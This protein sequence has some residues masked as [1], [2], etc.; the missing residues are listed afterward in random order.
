MKARNLEILQ[1]IANGFQLKNIAFKLNLSKS[2]IE[3]ELIL[4]REHLNA[5]TTAHAVKIAINKGLI[6]SLLVA[7]VSSFFDSHKYFNIKS[8]ENINNVVFS[9][10]RVVRTS[11]ARRSRRKRNIT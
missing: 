7:S 2:L 10:D 6:V 9:T 1:L 11:R 5:K 4:I 3:K 8:F